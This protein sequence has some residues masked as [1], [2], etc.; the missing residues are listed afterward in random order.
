MAPG[1]SACELTLTTI[2]LCQLLSDLI[3][4][5]DKMGTE[6]V[7]K[8]E[9]KSDDQPLFVLKYVARREIVTLKQRLAATRASSAYFPTLSTEV[10]SSSRYL[11]C[12]EERANLADLRI[13]PA[14]ATSVFT[15]LSHLKGSAQR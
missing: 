13:R 14:L 4:G 6:S 15:T 9:I 8:S 10:I 3:M 11:K 2:A 7:H 12:I 5:G 1:R